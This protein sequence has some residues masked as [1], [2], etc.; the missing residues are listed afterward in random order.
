MGK[1]KIKEATNDLPEE[2]RSKRSFKTQKRE[3]PFGKAIISVLDGT[4]LTREKVVQSVPFLFYLTLLA[5][6]Y[7]ANNYYAEKTI[8]HIERTKKESKELRSEYIT[9]KSEFM[10]K[11]RQSIIVPR[12]SPYGIK[13]SLIPPKK[14][15]VAKS[16]PKTISK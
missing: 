16:S 13:E 5:I 3:N 9:T 12:L 2:K 15:V 6:V 11:S 14:I 7:I 4:I 8:T 10:Y 1:N